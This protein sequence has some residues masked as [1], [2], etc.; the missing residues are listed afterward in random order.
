MVKHE[1]CPSCGSAN[2]LARW[3]DGHAHCFT[4]GC[5]YY[6]KAQSMGEDGE[7]YSSKGS[8]VKEGVL[9]LQGEVLPLPK[10]GLTEETCRLWGYRVGELNGRPAQFAYFFDDQKRPYAAKVR[11]ANKDF[12]IIGDTRNLGLYGKWL[13]NGGGKLIVV[14]EGEID[15]LSVS[16]VQNLRWPVVSV[17]NGAQG[18]VKAIKKDFDY[19]DSFDT[20]VFMFDM[21]EAGQTAATACAELFSPGKA[22]IASLPRKDANDCLVHGEDAQIVSAMW[23]AKVYRPDGIIDGTTLWEK[24]STVRDVRSVPY[25]YEGLNEKTHGLREG[26]LVTITAGSGVGK[27]AFVREISY[28]LLQQG[29][30]VGLIMLEESVERTAWGLMGIAC[31]KPLHISRSGVSQE[32]LRSA[33]DATCGTGRLFLYDHFGSTEVDNLLA[34]IRYMAKSLSCKWIILDHLSIVISGL[35]GEDERRLIDRAMTL[36]RTL[37]QETGIGLIL[38]SHL[39]RPDGK[40]HEEGAKT[41]LSQLRGSHAIAQLSDVVIGLERD[42]QGENPDETTVRVLKNRFSGD[43]GEACKLYYSKET[44]RLSNFTEEF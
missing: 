2:N 7:N 4:P 44:G 25:P 29:E 8:S 43:T 28:N 1:P 24:L 37:V 22:K 34:R 23:N 21:D 20:V 35:E 11:F 9:T 31:S 27:S 38:V 36:L 39:R 16:Q 40:G 17:P 5:G 3:E 33:F 18:A 19:L 10:R 12:T 32:E 41:S 14:T 6:E 26:E 30:T 13:W 15:A 42:Q